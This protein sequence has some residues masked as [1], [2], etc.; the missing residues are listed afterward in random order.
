MRPDFFAGKGKIHIERLKEKFEQDLINN[1]KI[2]EKTGV[3][4]VLS[5]MYFDAH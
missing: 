1:L 3:F 2:A 5:D 4:N